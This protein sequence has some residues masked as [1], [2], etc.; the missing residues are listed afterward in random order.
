[1]AS[2]PQSSADEQDEVEEAYQPTPGHKLPGW[3]VDALLEQ[4]KSKEAH[5]ELERLIGEGV[6]SGP[7]I[8]ATEVFWE[9]LYA[10][11]RGKAKT[12]R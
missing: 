11:A 3:T 6:N 1:M 2:N 8:E 7:G 10:L 12:D 4:G 9:D 5:L